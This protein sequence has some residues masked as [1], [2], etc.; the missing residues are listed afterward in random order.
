[1]AFL[2][3]LGLHCVVPAATRVRR[4]QDPCSIPSTT[5]DAGLHPI[6]SLLLIHQKQQ[7]HNP[8]CCAVFYPDKASG[9]Q[10]KFEEMQYLEGFLCPMPPKLAAL[11]PRER[12]GVRAP[13][14][15]C[16]ARHALERDSPSS[17]RISAHLGGWD[18]PEPWPQTALL[19]SPSGTP[20]LGDLFFCRAL[21]IPH[22]A[23]LSSSFIYLFLHGLLCFC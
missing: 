22:Q 16:C 23:Q 10:V 20:V 7:F 1:M 3:V 6:K 4:C 15:T 2:T 8:W 18:S 14:N 5:H 13:T 9:E 21:Y 17:H 19:A 11:Q 12:E